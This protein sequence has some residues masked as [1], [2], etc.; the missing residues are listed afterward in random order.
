MTCLVGDRKQAVPPRLLP[1]RDDLGVQ[2]PCVALE[3]A[4]Q[5]AKVHRDHE[6]LRGH[7]E[8]P[9]RVS[10][11]EQPDGAVER[12]KACGDDEEYEH[13]QRG[14]LQVALTIGNRMLRS[15]ER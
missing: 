2:S 4:V 1:R 11:R 13:A 5:R 9:L 14:E 7:T 10:G 15:E 6:H 8:T 3:R 12:N